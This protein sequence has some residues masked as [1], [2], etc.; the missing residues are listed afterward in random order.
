MQKEQ[1][2]PKVVEATANREYEAPAIEK[3][4]TAEELTRK[5]HHAGTAD[6][7]LAVG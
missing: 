7:T 4:M 1:Q 3:V 6:A 2:A 5:V